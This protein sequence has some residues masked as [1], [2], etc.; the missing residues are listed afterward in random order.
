[1]YVFLVGMIKV[2][3]WREIF[4]FVERVIVFLE[5]FVMSFKMFWNFGDKFVESFCEEDG[6]D[7]VGWFFCVVLDMILDCWMKLNF[8]C[9][10]FLI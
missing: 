4:G 10:E 2:G 1:M 3:S 8:V 7:E 6:V 5:Y 9:K